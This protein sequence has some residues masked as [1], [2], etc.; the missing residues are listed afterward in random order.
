MVSCANSNHGWKISEAPMSTFFFGPST[1]CRCTQPL[2]R[3]SI[4]FCRNVNRE[5]M[6]RQ[7]R[8]SCRWHGHSSRIGCVHE[9]PWVL[10]VK[11]ADKERGT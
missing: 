5:L 6:D 7:G 1:A 9:Y 4:V 2:D 3:S 10:M 8:M 11:G